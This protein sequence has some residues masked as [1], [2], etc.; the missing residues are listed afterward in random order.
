MANSGQIYFGIASKQTIHSTGLY[1]DGNWH[2]VDATLSSA[3]MALYIDGAPVATNTK[4]T[5]PG[6]YNGYWRV[7]DE[8]TGGWS[9]HGNN[10][11]TGTIDEAAVYPTAL[12]AAR[13]AAHH[14][15][16]Q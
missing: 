9:A 12:T 11:F 3:G 7:G 16:A 4:T 14:E 5:I 6:P 1:N 2:L 10:F 8:S 15:A 13:I